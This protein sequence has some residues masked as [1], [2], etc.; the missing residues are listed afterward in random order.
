MTLTVWLVTDKWMEECNI[1]ILKEVSKYQNKIVGNSS[2]S[3]VGSRK[4]ITNRPG[5]QNNQQD[6]EIVHTGGDMAS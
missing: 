2:C 4:H 3:M 5:P 1:D 6:P